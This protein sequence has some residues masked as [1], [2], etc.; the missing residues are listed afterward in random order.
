MDRAK[1]GD[2][3]VFT[4]NLIVVPDVA[5]MAPGRGAEMRA[6][7]KARS[8]DAA[9]Q[10]GLTGLKALGVRDLTY[11]LCFLASMVQPADARVSFFLRPFHTFSFLFS[12]SLFPHF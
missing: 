12:F 7:A 3:C 10:E 4:G 2:K 8:K 6:G 5:Q 11:K 1:P 9:P